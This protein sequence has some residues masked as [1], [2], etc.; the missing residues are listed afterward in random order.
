MRNRGVVA[1]EQGDTEWAARFPLSRAGPVNDQL[2]VAEAFAG[3]G[4]VVLAS[5]RNPEGAGTGVVDRLRS[6]G[7]VHIVQLDVTDPG[8]RERAIDDAVAAH[9]GLDVLVNTGRLDRRVRVVVR[10]G[11]ACARCDGLRP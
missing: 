9:G 11:Q 7:D 1:R 5:M 3:R 6:A 2:V 8:S 4:D 10:G